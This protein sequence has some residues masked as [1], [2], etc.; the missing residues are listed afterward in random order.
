MLIITI[1]ATILMLAAIPV[2]AINPAEPKNANAIWLE[3]STITVSGGGY[4]VYL[5]AYNAGDRF[6][7]TLF[8]NCSVTC[9][10]WSIRL[11]CEK[12]YLNI[13]GAVYTMPDESK[14]EYFQNISAIPV[15]PS[16]VSLNSTHWRIDYGE[17]W[18]G[19]GPKRDPG[20]GS[21]CKIEFNVTNTGPI[22]TTLAFADYTGTIRKTYLI[23]A[24]DNSK[25]DL[26][27]YGGQVVPEFNPAILLTILATISIPTAI[28]IR[29]KKF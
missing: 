22:F 13:T 25:V 17:S 2:Y 1:I 12:A 6:N 8:A 27:V 24:S 18:S 11:T 9:G 21:L 5:G 10:G 20:Y 28:I 29:R 4:L 3:P 7:V 26:N 23:D 14:S 15:N 16:I 19:T